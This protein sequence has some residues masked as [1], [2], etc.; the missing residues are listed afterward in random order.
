VKPEKTIID[1]DMVAIFVP[2]NIFGANLGGIFNII[3]PNF[4]V[5]VCLFLFLIFVIYKLFDKAVETY[6][7]E[8]AKM[9]KEQIDIAMIAAEAIQM[10]PE[11]GRATQ[12]EKERF[13]E[14][15]V[16]ATQIKLQEMNRWSNFVAPIEADNQ[17]KY[18]TNIKAD[19]N[20]NVYENY[21][22]TDRQFRE[23]SVVGKLRV[24]GFNITTDTAV[25]KD[26]RTKE[27]QKAY[28]IVSRIT[29]TKM[30][31]NDKGGNKENLEDKFASLN[32]PRSSMVG[33]ENEILDENSP[34]FQ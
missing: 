21:E 27:E 34:E 2:L 20:K 15:V 31:L 23:K 8:S 29:A 33:D 30:D 3:F 17:G 22:K 28:Q 16:R 32:H 26:F 10:E 7:K 5:D 19:M 25:H 11:I 18:L 13:V 6:G 12:I 9:K 4:I 14:D 1:Y 24:T